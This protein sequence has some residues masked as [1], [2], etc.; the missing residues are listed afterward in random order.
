MISKTADFDLTEPAST[1]P[2]TIEEADQDLAF[3][4]QHCSTGQLMVQFVQGEEAV[5]F[6]VVTPELRTKMLSLLIDGLGNKLNMV[7]GE[8]APK[9]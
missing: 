5:C 1:R 2:S 9:A 8:E 3:V 4:G 6:Q 7:R